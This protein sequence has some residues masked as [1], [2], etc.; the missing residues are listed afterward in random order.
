M[1]WLPEHTML[2]IEAEI[3]GNQETTIRATGRLTGPWVAE[4]QRSLPIREEGSLVLDLTDVS[5]VDRDGIEL[6]RLLTG[7]SRIRL[8]CSAFVT[9]QLI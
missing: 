4:L 6:L 9:A 8:R 7:D 1:L 5:F 3:S 2:R